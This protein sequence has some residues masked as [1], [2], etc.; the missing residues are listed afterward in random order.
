MLKMREIWAAD[1]DQ[2]T[3]GKEIGLNYDQRIMGRTQG[4][5]SASEVVGY[6]NVLLI[7][8]MESFFF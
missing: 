1:G 8:F 7:V 5:P 3:E 6:W 4:S 2:R